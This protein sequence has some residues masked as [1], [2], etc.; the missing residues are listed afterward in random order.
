VE[1]DEGGALGEGN[2]D[3]NEPSTSSTVLR[4]SVTTTIMACA[5]RA[6]EGPKAVCPPSID[7]G[8]LVVTKDNVAKVFAA[9][10]KK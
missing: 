7:T 2:V 8:A 1:R 10:N 3:P 9:L 6:S 5:P 4:L